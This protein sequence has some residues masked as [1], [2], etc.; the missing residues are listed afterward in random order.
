M[1]LYNNKLLLISI[2]LETKN[3]FADIVYLKT[4]INTQIFH[5]EF[6]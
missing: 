1:N 4:K 6:I 2:N 5:T 3:N